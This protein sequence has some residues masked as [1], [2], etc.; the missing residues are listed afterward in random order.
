VSLLVSYLQAMPVQRSG[1]ERAGGLAKAKCKS[2]AHGCVRIGGDDAT[3][4]P[5]SAGRYGAEAIMIGMPGG[6]GQSASYLLIAHGMRERGVVRVPS[7]PSFKPKSGLVPARSWL[8]AT[9]CAL[10]PVA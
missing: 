2:L 5:D 10:L 7:S 9:A 3:T 6:R 1:R 8:L 4:R